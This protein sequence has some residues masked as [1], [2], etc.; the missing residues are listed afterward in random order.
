[1]LQPGE[2]APDFTLDDQDRNPVTLSEKVGSGSVVLFFYPRALTRGCTAESCHFRDL[3]SEFQAVG[4]QAIGIS[5]D[6]PERQS[7]FDRRHSLGLTLLSDPDRSVARSFG[8][9]RPGPLSNRRATFVIGTD[10][11]VLAAY[12]SE[13]NMEMHADRALEILKASSPT[14]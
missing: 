14:T 7:E 4:A 6:S 10:Q 2:L 9:K 5:T 1:M 8:I 13:F 11:R 12:S 3:R